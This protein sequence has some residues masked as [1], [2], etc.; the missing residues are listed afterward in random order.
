MF[1][2]KGPS[3]CSGSSNSSIIHV[4]VPKICTLPSAITSALPEEFDD[5]CAMGRRKNKARGKAF[6]W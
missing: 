1:D 2:G 5:N 4:N 6:P 3:I